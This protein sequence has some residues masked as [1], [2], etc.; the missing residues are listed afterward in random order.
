[1][2][3]S[4]VTAVAFTSRSTIIQVGSQKTRGECS[5]DAAE[6]FPP[7]GPL[8][9]TLRL[10]DS[11]SPANKVCTPLSDSPEVLNVGDT[12][13]FFS[14]PLP[15]E[16]AN[17]SPMMTP[18]MSSTPVTD[19]S[20]RRG[21]PETEVRFRENLFQFLNMSFTNSGARDLRVEQ[22]FKSYL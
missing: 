9:R 19:I 1:V 13:D 7:P 21:P 6:R 4:P 17:G 20:E 12:G 15:N 2:T 11:A 8:I 18:Q 10:E 5:L 16:G 22:R 3:F 14:P